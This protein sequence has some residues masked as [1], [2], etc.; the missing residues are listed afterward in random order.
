MHGVLADITHPNRAMIEP[1]PCRIAAYRRRRLRLPAT[2]AAAS[3]RHPRVAGLGRS[4]RGRSRRPG[5]LTPL[6][7]ISLLTAISLHRLRRRRHDLHHDHRQYHVAVR[8]ASPFR[9]RRWCSWRASAIGT[10]GAFAGRLAIRHRRDRGAQG[11]IVGYFRANPIL[12][13]HRRAGAHHRRSPN[14]SPAGSAFIQRRRTSRSSRS[15]IAGIPVET[16][17]FFAAVVARP[18]HPVAGRGSA[19]TCAWSAAIGAPPKP[20]ASAPPAVVTGA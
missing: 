20:P 5:F 11:V 9:P 13:K 19:A 3:C 8:W 6:S 10:A 15:R 16:L 2:G 14:S 17:V 4:P 18:D 1:C 7:I 12:R